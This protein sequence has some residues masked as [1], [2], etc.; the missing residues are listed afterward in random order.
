MTGIAKHWP[1]ILGGCLLT[2]TALIWPRPSAVAYH[3]REFDRVKT[4]Y[5]NFRPSISD[6]SKGIRSNQD[7]WDFHLENLVKLGA[8][9]HQRF[10]FTEVPYTKEAAGLIFRAAV[11]NFPAAVMFSAKD[12]QP[13]APGYGVTP[14]V[15]EVWDTPEQMDRWTNFFKANRYKQ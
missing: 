12:F 4:N 6:L 14:Y 1:W 5:N 3:F 2:L 13:N 11:S 15:L 7:K 9:V 8:V 10:V